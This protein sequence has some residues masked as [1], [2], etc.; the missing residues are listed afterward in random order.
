MKYN[1]I[2]ENINCWKKFGKTRAPKK[3]KLQ[4]KLCINDLNYFLLPI[5]FW[6]GSLKWPI[7]VP[8]N[9]TYIQKYIL[10]LILEVV[11]EEINIYI[12]LHVNISI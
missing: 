6:F 3:D 11:L 4:C 7:K 5:K 2:K 12:E 10:T 1:S 9:A 8:N